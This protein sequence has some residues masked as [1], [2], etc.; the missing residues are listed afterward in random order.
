[1]KPHQHIKKSI[2]ITTTLE[3]LS[4]DEIAKIFQLMKDGK[5]EELNT[6]HLVYSV[7]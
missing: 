2:G 1:M 3:H 6:N 4:Q 5:R 7:G